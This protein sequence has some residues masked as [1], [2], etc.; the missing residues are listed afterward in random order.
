MTAL[1]D[2]AL[3]H[4]GVRDRLLDRHDD[5]VADRGVLAPRAAEHLDAH[6]LLGARVVGDVE[7]GVV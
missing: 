4:L 3:L 6:D 5:D 7:G 1:R 2:L